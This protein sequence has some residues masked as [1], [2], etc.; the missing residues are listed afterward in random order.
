MFAS[1]FYIKRNFFQAEK[2]RNM[3]KKNELQ[4]RLRKI[5]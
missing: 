3:K 2:R 1:N 4:D 5:H